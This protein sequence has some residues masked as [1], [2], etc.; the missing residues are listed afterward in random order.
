MRL[1]KSGLLTL[2]RVTAAIALGTLWAVPAGLGIGLSPRLS[3]ILQ[4]VVQVAA[5]F[6]AP[7]LFP[8]VILVLACSESA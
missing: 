7:M 2:A 4:P 8:V 1:L 3:R 5:S 6:P